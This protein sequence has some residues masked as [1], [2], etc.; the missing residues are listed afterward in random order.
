MLRSISTLYDYAIRAR[1]G[2][3]GHV[4]DFLFDDNLW[5]IRYLVADTGNWLP[6]RQVLLS[7]LSPGRPDWRRQIF[8]VELSQEQVENSPP[9]SADQPVSRQIEADLYAYYG[10]RPY[11]LGGARAMLNTLQYQ[12]QQGASKAEEGDPNLRSTREVRGYHI[13]AT[14]GEVGHIDDFIANDES[15]TI[16]YLV[17][18][19]R[20]WLQG[21]R[22]LIAPAWV[23][24]VDW[25][26][27][28]V[29]LDLRR[30]TIEKSPEFDPEVPVNREYEMR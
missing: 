8:P 26:E 21:K 28:L 15:W 16:H 1:D 22:V 2:D 30:K 27:K 23:T 10:W 17:V 6:G 3:I 24:K 4:H 25:V 13:Q 9:I 29:Y 14:D 20:N 18:D 5:L 7:P 12:A 19:T 11:W